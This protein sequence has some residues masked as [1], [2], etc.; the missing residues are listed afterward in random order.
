MPSASGLC[1]MKLAVSRPLLYAVVAPS[2]PERVFAAVVAATAFRRAML[3]TK[4][5]AIF[6]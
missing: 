3:A 1:R 5:L 2:A 6:C 4:R